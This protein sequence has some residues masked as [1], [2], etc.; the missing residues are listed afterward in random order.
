MTSRDT[1]LASIRRHT[2]ERFPLPDLAPLEQKALRF[3]DPVG[4]FAAVMQQVGGRAVLLDDGDTPGQCLARLYP[5]AK[6]VALAVSGLAGRESL[7]G[8][9]FDPDALAEPA[10]LNGTD[11]AIVPAQL[12]VCENGCCWI[13]Q[14]V[15][16]RALYFIAEALAIVLR[17]AD[18][19][20][21]MHE[22]YARLADNPE[23]A[24]GCF[25]SGPSKTADIEQALVMGA[26][27]AREVTVLLC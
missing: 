6:R 27:G 19:V 23:L 25:I 22:A 1:I 15:R 5:S 4:R 17:R 11:L 13:P 16:H 2:T 10:E 7:P 8:Q 20:H 24:F 14:Q 12:G 21:N 26:H 9:V 18:L 3:D